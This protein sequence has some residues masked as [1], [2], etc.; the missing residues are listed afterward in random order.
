VGG[1]ARSN[2]A[3]ILS[4]DTVDLSWD[5]EANGAVFALA[6]SGSTVY[7]GGQ[8]TSTGSDPFCGFA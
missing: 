5:P 2:I 8:F 7:T 1:V 4:N 3:H 6:V